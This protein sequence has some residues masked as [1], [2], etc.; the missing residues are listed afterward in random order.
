MRFVRWNDLSRWENLMFVYAIKSGSERVCV[1]LNLYLRSGQRGSLNES[2]KVKC[3]TNTKWARATHEKTKERESGQ[4]QPKNTNFRITY[5]ESL[6]VITSHIFQVRCLDLFRVIVA[7]V[8]GVICP[9]MRS[10]LDSVHKTHLVMCDNLFC[11]CRC[12][13]LFWFLV[14]SLFFVF[15]FFG[16]PA[17]YICSWLPVPFHSSPIQFTITMWTWSRARIRTHSWKS[18]VP[19]KPSP[20]V[21]THFLSTASVRPRS[22]AASPKQ[23]EEGKLKRIPCNMA[24]HISPRKCDNRTNTD[25]PEMD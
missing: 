20:G 19:I 11:F 5:S 7:V 12:R 15:A 23:W 24:P 16:S 1:C 2:N 6:D 14:D 22:P 4:P 18:F 17:P 10:H 3:D 13:W 9:P 21:C 25:T 8:A